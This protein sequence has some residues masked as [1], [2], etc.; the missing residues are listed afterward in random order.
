LE[1]EVGA[2]M[3]GGGRGAT[4]PCGMRIAGA[5]LKTEIVQDLASWRAMV[6]ELLRFFAVFDDQFHRSI[7]RQT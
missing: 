5:S 7:N 2:I 6:S 4:L 1:G 3:H